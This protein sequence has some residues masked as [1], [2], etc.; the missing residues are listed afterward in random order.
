MP[1][2]IVIPCATEAAW[3]A[4]RAKALGASEVAALFGAHPYI[5]PLQ[6]WTKK[7]EQGATTEEETERMEAGHFAEL[8]VAPWYAK[9]TGRRVVTP[10]EFYCDPERK[11]ALADAVVTSLG[12]RYPYAVIVRHPTI[13]LQATPDRIVTGNLQH[14]RHE[15]DR[16]VSHPGVLQI[17]ATEDWQD[18]WS[19]DEQGQ[20]RIPLWVQIQVQAELLCTGF[21]WGAVAVDISGSKLRYADVERHEPFMATLAEKVSA[22]WASLAGDVAPAPTAGDLETIKRQWPKSV[23]GLS[24]ELER[25]EHLLELARVKAEISQ[26]EEQEK[27]LQAAIVAELGPAE[28]GTIQ[29]RKVVT[30][31]TTTRTDPPR[32]EAVTREY[33]TLRLDALVKQAKA[34]LPRHASPPI[35]PA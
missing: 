29:G 4:E 1:E 24:K 33:R 32:P 28:E 23:P 15:A 18:E 22:F 8:K 3:H 25:P 21:T 7:K 2:P 19:D 30:L 12:G 31:K 20:L 16:I 10:Q 34:A 11:H 6:L 9:R 17:K 13:P 26:L 14:E 5:T 27:A 35:L